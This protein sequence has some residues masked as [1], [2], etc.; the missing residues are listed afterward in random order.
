M[1]FSTLLFVELDLK[2]KKKTNK[3]TACRNT[4]NRKN[5]ESRF[6]DLGRTVFQQT[7]MKLTVHRH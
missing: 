4:V 5:R 3:P 1:I 7:G 2:K 6:H